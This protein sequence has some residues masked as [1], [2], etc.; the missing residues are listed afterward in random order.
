MKT[1]VDYLLVSLYSMVTI[2]VIGVVIWAASFGF[3]YSDESFYY[4]G[5]KYFSNTPNLH[6]APFHR[7]LHSIFGWFDPS[8]YLLRISRLTL[9]VFT[10]FGLFYF[11]RKEQLSKHYLIENLTLICVILMGLFVSYSKGP[12]SISY[13]SLST[14]LIIWISGI[15]YNSLKSQGEIIK[16]FQLIVIGGM[17]ALLLFIKITNLLLFPILFIGSAIWLRLHPTKRPGLKSIVLQLIV[18]GSGALLILFLLTSESQSAFSLVQETISSVFS[19][20]SNNSGHSLGDLGDKYWTNLEQVWSRIDYL[21][22]LIIALFIIC[23]SYQSFIKNAISH[24]LPSIFIGVTMTLLLWLGYVD[25]HWLAGTTRK[26]QILDAY[27]LLWLIVYLHQFL[28]KNRPPQLWLFGLLLLPVCGAIGTNNGLSSQFLYYGAFIFFGIWW[29]INSTEHRWKKH[30]VISYL[31]LFSASQVITGIIS[32]P[33]RQLDLR[34]SQQSIDLQ[35]CIG[36][37][38]VDPFTY[39]LFEKLISYRQTP[40]EYVF[41]FSHQSGIA[42][43]LDKKPFSLQWINS[44]NSIDLCFA[45]ARNGIEADNLLFAVPTEYPLSKEDKQCFLENR[46][47][48]NEYEVVDVID[49]YDFVR[50]QKQHLEILRHSD[51]NPPR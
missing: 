21:F 19:K 45:T 1:K 35:A 37:I 46:I 6:G 2:I 8:I 36:P 26:Y 49:Y 12:Q 40:E 48:F 51:N 10:G 31:I 17:F 15:W 20:T 23:K 7:V 50:K 28:I 13:N 24:Y 32:D 29:M 47:D 27:I 43:L 22:L 42:L 38:K 44:G 34:E 5:Y 3:E 30:L 9:Y 33:Y 4:L 41:T 39:E 11:I 16:L 14:I 25:Q 18:M